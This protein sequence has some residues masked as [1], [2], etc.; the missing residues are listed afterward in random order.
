MTISSIDMLFRSKWFL[1][2]KLKTA[3]ILFGFSNSKPVIQCSSDI[4]DPRRRNGGD[5]LPPSYSEA[6]FEKMDLSEHSL[7]S[8]PPMD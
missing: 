7:P 6:E 8:A 5:E 1:R 3:R 2:N 4:S